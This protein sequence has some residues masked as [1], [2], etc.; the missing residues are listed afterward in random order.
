MAALRFGRFRR[1]RAVEDIGDDFIAPRFVGVAQIVVVVRPVATSCEN[2]SMTTSSNKGSPGSCS[3]S[4]T[5][6][7]HQNFPHHSE[8]AGRRRH[9]T[10]TQMKPVVTWG[11][12]LRR[13]P[14]SIRDSLT[15]SRAAPPHNPIDPL[16]TLGDGGGR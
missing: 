7:G 13:F 2:S 8:T 6:R 5:K 10:T 3:R 16:A 1:R 15:E 11:E 4:L 12:E 14:C 9:K